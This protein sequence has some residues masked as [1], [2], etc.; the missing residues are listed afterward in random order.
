M[1][2]LP[3]TSA[4]LPHFLQLTPL[5]YLPSAFEVMSRVAYILLRN[6]ARRCLW[7]LARSGQ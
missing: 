5:W 2:I 3:A 1:S 7:S 6:H 4:H